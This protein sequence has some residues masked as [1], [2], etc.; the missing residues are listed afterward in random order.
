MRKILGSVVKLGI[1]VLTVVIANFLLSAP[2]TTCVEAGGS[3][4]FQLQICDGLEQPT[5][6]LKLLRRETLFLAGI[7]SFLTMVF[8]ALFE[9]ILKKS[10]HS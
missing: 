6:F 5:Q 4:N 3:F 1:I 2:Q 8:L 9:R 10:S 7:S